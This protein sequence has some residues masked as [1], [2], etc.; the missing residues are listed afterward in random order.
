MLKTAKN[1]EIEALKND[2][3][4][5]TSQMDKL[6]GETAASDPHE[7]SGTISRVTPLT[8]VSMLS[9][10][11]VRRRSPFVRISELLVET[12]EQITYN[13]LQTLVWVTVA[14]AGVL[15]LSVWQ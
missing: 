8:S 13:L 15:L 12:S 9:N 6:T 1:S 4:I 5:L 2:I 14:V 7:A 11:A 10:I 3:R